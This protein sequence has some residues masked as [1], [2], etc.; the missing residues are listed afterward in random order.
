MRWRRV[1]AGLGLGALALGGV[2]VTRTLLVTSRQITAP[3]APAVAFDLDAAAERLA[4]AIRI[5]TVSHDDAAEDDAAAFARL[6]AFLAEAYPRLHAAATREV[7][8]G[9]ELLY[10][11]PGRDAAAPPILFL[12][13]QDVVPVDDAAAWT[14]PPFGGVQADGFIWGR[15]ALDDKNG[16]LAWMEAAETLLAQGFQPAATIYLAFGSDEESGGAGARK[17]A[18][19]LKNRGVRPRLVLDEGGVIGEGLVPGLD[20]PVALIGIA[21]KGYLTLG[22]TARDVGGHSSQPPPQTAVGRLARAISRLEADPFPMRIDG[23]ARHFMDWLAPELGFGQRLALANRWLLGPVIERIYARKRST[24]ASLRTTTAATRIV[25]GTKEN[26]L[27]TEATARV[28]FRLLPGDDAASVE[29]RVRAVIND[30]EVTI[31]RVGPVA[32]PSALTDPDGPGFR[33]LQR[34]AAEVIPDALV[35]PY[36]MLGYTD[37]RAYADLSDQVLRFSA[38][39]FDDADLRRFHGT[40]ERISRER[41]AEQIRFAIRML[42]TIE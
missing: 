12:A 13:H 3:P 16:I 14:H 23:A 17:L 10:T 39:R 8:E 29:A 41:Y 11:W 5:P 42:Q 30:D 7:V 28:N 35:I 37:A 38:V 20:R 9:R 33:W 25:G 18:T 2:L 19:I 15:G 21:E 26:T 6:H 24:A 22:L 31:E 27:P 40:D 36:L 32:E 1:L 34:A 4:L